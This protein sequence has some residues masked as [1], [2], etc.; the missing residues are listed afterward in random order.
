MFR[1]KLLQLAGLY[2]VLCDRYDVTS[3]DLVAEMIVRSVGL[4]ATKNST[5]LMLTSDGKHL[6]NDRMMIFPIH[7]ILKGRFFEYLFCFF[8]MI[9]FA[10]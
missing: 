6:T 4:R 1:K 8:C 7:I 2:F 5:Q 3:C 10:F 9:L